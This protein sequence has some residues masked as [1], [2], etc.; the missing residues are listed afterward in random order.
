[1]KTIFHKKIVW[2]LLILLT[3]ACEDWEWDNP[4]DENNTLDKD[5]WAPSELKLVS[6]NSI[7]YVTLQWKSSNMNYSGYVIEK[8]EIGKD[9]KEIY[10]EDQHNEYTDEDEVD[11]RTT[12]YTYRVRAMA[13]GNY[14]GSSNELT[15]E[16]PEIEIDGFGYHEDS[17][18]YCL[19]RIVKTGSSDV[20]KAGIIYALVDHIN[21][22]QNE[23]QEIDDFLIRHWNDDENIFRIYDEEVEDDKPIIN[24]K[25]L[26][27]GHYHILPFAKNE[28]GYGY[29]ERKTLTRK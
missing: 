9:W 28:E 29:G 17:G 21:S 11:L 19:L 25:D 13:S 5:E 12:G 26:D 18:P 23:P 10:T 16:M 22:D 14:S 24:L 27:Q 2:V 3:V 20:R 8:K 1:M 4:H 15:I 7:D 6:T